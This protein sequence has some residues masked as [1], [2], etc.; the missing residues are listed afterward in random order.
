VVSHKGPSDVS[1]VLAL[2]ERRYRELRG[3]EYPDS[4]E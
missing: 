4:V 1:G 3:E 2:F